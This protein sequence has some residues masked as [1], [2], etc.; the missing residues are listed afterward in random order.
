MSLSCILLFPG[1]LGL[2]NIEQG[3]YLIPSVQA[4]RHKLQL[5]AQKPKAEQ[6]AAPQPALTRT[7]KAVRWPARMVSCS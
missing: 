3:P 6:V 7:E 5:F 1:L 2:T 4:A